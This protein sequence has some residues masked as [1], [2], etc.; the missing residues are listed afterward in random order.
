[1]AERTKAPVSKTGM[2]VCSSWVRIP[3][4]P[5]SPLEK[6]F[7]TLVKSAA[8]TADQYLSELSCDRRKAIGVVRDVVLKSLPEGFQE[9]MQFG[10]ISYVVPLET[11]PQTYNGKPLMYAALASQKS[12]MSLYLMSIYGDEDTAKRFDAEYASSGKKKMDRGKSCVRFKEAGDLPLEVIGRAVAGTSM[13][14]FIDIYQ[15]SRRR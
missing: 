14:D 5:P 11:F 3:L 4:S 7:R 12:Y 15:R 2:G 10:M 13:K 6:S 9:E 8:S 1:M